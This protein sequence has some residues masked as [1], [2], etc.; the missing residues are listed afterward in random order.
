MSHCCILGHIVA[1][2][3]G[4]VVRIGSGAGCTGVPNGDVKTAQITIVVVVESLVGIWRATGAASGDSKYGCSRKIGGGEWLH[5]KRWWGWDI[6]NL[7][8]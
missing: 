4:L 8:G 1:C 3:A 6:P 2:A 5:G 7:G